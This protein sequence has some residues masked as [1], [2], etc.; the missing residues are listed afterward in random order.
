MVELD[1]LHAEELRQIPVRK[2]TNPRLVVP[3][4]ITLAAVPEVLAGVLTDDVAD[5]SLPAS[6]A[7]TGDLV[8]ASIL[9]GTRSPGLLRGSVPER[10]R[11]V[12]TEV[13]TNAGMA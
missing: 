6:L 3:R 10:R 1:S 5:P 12:R 11:P 4:A 13:P 2:R 9:P 8:H 7:P